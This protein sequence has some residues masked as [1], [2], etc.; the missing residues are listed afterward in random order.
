MSD[1][2]N[3][4]NFKNDGQRPIYRQILSHI[5]KGIVAGTICDGDALP[6]RRQLSALLGINPNTVQK[7]FGI[8]E[9]Q[10]LIETRAGAKSVM[11]L[12]EDKIKEIRRMLLTENIVA[13]T[14][15]MRQMSISKEEALELVSKYW[16][17]TDDR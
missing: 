3:F 4:E 2:I 13:L 8:L 9:Q 15:S 10:G 12:D 11:I 7:A 5:M 6:S 14:E 1:T 17:E 16:E